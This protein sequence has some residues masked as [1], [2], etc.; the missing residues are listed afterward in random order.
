MEIN[1][2]NFHIYDDNDDSASWSSEQ[3]MQL[4]TPSTGDS[5]SLSAMRYVKKAMGTE[6]VLIADD[7][8]GACDGGAAFLACAAPVRVWLNWAV[9]DICPSQ[10]SVFSTESRNGT[11]QQARSIL[12]GVAE[13]L[14]TVSTEALIYKKIDSAGRGHPGVEILA[15]LEG[16]CCAWAICTPALPEAGRSVHQGV[17][18][19]QDMAGQDAR[20]ALM[21]AFAADFRNLVSVLSVHQSEER[22]Q[23]AMK[24]ALASGSRVLLCDAA[25]AEDLDRIVRAAG[26]VNTDRGDRML[27]AGSAGLA[28]ALARDLQP[29]AGGPSGSEICGEE[30]LDG[31]S[32]MFIGSPHAVTSFQLQKLETTLPTQ[33]L[34]LEEATRTPLRSD[35]CVVVRVSC[36][37]D[38]EEHIRQAWEACS[39]LKIRSVLLTGGDTAS[40]VLR[41]L[42]TQS[43]LLRGR[44]LPTVPWGVL[45]GGLADGHRVVTK[46]GGFGTEMALANAANF[47]GWKNF[48]GAGQ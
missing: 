40:L 25:S 26:R 19:I 10:M 12:H 16:F 8:T 13:V 6:M 5:V 48:S 33:I 22:L 20:M 4:Q 15:A 35:G 36:G 21:E 47:S 30:N 37:V 44:V 43:I 45:E 2:Y 11:S 29:T 41:A 17:L 46:S 14:N 9:A 38:P 18:H 23:T 31:V 34:S 39:R 42:H 32:L 3:P 7:L 1:V 24:A 28:Q 27:W